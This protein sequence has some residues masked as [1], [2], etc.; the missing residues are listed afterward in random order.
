MFKEM[1]AGCGAGMSQ[2]IVTTPMEMLK[3]QLQ[4]AGRLGKKNTKLCLCLYFIVMHHLSVYEHIFLFLLL[5]GPAAK[6]SHDVAHKACC[7]QRCAQSLL[8]LWPC[9][10]CTEGCVSHT[11][12]QGAPP[13]SGHP[14][15]LQ[16]SGGNA[17][18]VDRHYSFS[19]F[20]PDVK[21]N[22]SY[23]V[24]MIMVSYLSV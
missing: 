10:V 12:C 7:H 22:V 14:G 6:T 3:I 17:D 23:S 15:P 19:Y 9:G 4:D 13:Y 1:L 21:A 5:S 2:V 8:Q 18:E 16:R 20:P 24:L 11:D